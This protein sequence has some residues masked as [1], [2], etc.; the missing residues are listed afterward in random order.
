M[1]KCEVV[2]DR[3]TV[4]SVF[5]VLFVCRCFAIV[6]IL[7]SYCLIYGDVDVKV[8]NVEGCQ[9]MVFMYL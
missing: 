7:Y 4:N 9:F 6:L 1:L 2:C 3:I 8:F 5:V